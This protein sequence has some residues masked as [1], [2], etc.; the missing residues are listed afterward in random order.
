MTPDLRERLAEHFSK[1]CCAGDFT[2][3]KPCDYCVYLAKM[4]EPFIT[5]HFNKA[6][7][8]G[9]KDEHLK[10]CAECYT[11]KLSKRKTKCCRGKK[12]IWLQA[13]EESK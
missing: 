7:L 11:A 4:T 6:R 12:L 3:K 5:Q 13:L 10:L 8:E 1:S 2:E 9:K